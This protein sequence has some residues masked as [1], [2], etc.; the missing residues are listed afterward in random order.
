MMLVGYGGLSFGVS[1]IK[2][3][4]IAILLLVVNAILFWKG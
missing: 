1:D 2:G 3:K 4:I